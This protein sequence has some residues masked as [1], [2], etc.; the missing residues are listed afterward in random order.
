MASSARSRTSSSMGYPDSPSTLILV[1]VV[2][3]LS[4]LAPKLGGV[5]ISNPQTIWPLWPGGAILVS[6]L[7][8]APLR[9]WPILISV[10][11]AGFVFYDL[12]VGVSFGSI[13]W[14][15][16]AD[17]VQVLIAAL[18]L[19]Y[20]FDGVPRLNS[21][22]ALAKYSF[23][24]VILAPMAAA[25][26]SARGIHADYWNGW[27]IC[28][29]SE[30]LAFVTITP[31]ILSWVSEG[32]AWVRKSHA[33]HLEAVALIA[34]LFLLG[35]V[36]FT[37]S[38]K[39]SS[40]ALLYS[41]VPF[42]LWSALR[43]GAMGVSTSVVVVAFLSIWGAVH[44]RG[45][46]AEQGP[47][48]SLLSLQLFLIFAATPFMVLAAV[49]EERKHT[50][51]ALRNSEE[52][53]R[54]AAQAGRMFAYE[55]DA[56]TDVIVRSSES[57]QIL[58]IDEA[59]RVTGQQILTRVH[60]E[61]RNRLLGAVAALSPEKPHLQVSYRMV[62]PDGSVIWVERNSRAHFDEQGTLLRIVGMVADVTDRKHAEEA[63]RHSEERFRLAAQAGKMYAYE[64]DVASDTV[65]RSEESV[66]VLGF[67]DQA[68]QLTRQQLVARVHP[69]DRALFIGSVDQLTP[70]NPTIHI[71]YRVLR[72]DGSVVW[73]EKSARAFFDEKGKLQ[74]TI[75]MV[76]DITER[77]RAEEAL[78]ES[79]DKLRLLLDS[80]AEAIY[81]I[82]LEGHCTF[83]NPA[84]LRAL[85]YE[86][87]DELLGKNMHHLIHH[88]REDGTLFPVEECRIFQ[89][90]QSREGVHVDDE[91]LWRAN[92]TSFPAEYWSYPQRRG[93]E[94]VGAV[95]AFIDITQR[96]RAEEALAS[97]SRRLIAAQEQERTRIARELH[98]DIGQRLAL[99]A[100]ELEQFQQNFPDLSPEVRS[101]MGELQM[102]T[103]EISTDIQSLSHELHSSKLE[104]LGIAAA[105]RGFCK[106]FGEQQ[107]VAIDFTTHDLP[108]A[109]PPD[110][111]LC[112]FRVLQ[113]ALHNSAKHSGVRDFEVRLWAT[114]SEI[115][116]TIGDSGAGFDSEAA[117]ESRGLGLI[118]MEERL[119]LLKGTFSIESQPK[120]GTT[121]HAR[122]P[123]SSGRDSMLAAG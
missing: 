33:Y 19:R 20:C 80:T 113:E 66:G 34:G 62:R 100:I 99:L 3:T 85:G 121:I 94:V 37:E 75:G 81:G 120:R 2:A 41:L 114:S 102:H 51:E 103:S 59:M 44:G 25:F 110:I 108:N 115:H 105:M 50:E 9:I 28:F 72:P 11:F 58:G 106:E 67:S 109:L 87:V 39:N 96:K 68:K 64:W 6:G 79:E 92:G 26:L 8:L 73:L 53:F 5:L 60:P 32:R 38:E 13:A 18:G 122:V 47:V 78:R 63:L 77:K 98:D 48:S 1:C 30:V 117:K 57:A 42:L 82:D 123:L 116:L 65:M 24:A 35:Y 119:K 49:V 83:C 29:F 52:R 23:F 21:V 90:F 17:T 107:K 95:V 27:R 111:S 36:T 31:A 16:V 118:S 55:W 43:F 91:M 101:G 46:F 14:F 40:P 71:S 12:E 84:C 10:A 15:M 88:S 61:D 4:Y 56:V 97:V 45:P 7:L 69:D 112:L 70:E 86:G 76:A 74:R 54:L 104:H 22:K 89:A 93:Q